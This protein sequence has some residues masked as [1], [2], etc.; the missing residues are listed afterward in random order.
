MGQVSTSTVEFTSDAFTIR[1]FL[2]RPPPAAAAPAVVVIQEWW[3]V[4]D[5]IKDIA[6]RFAREGYVAFAPDLYSRLGYQVTK[7]ATEAANLMA[8]LSSQAALRD[9]NAA[10]QCLTQQPGVDNRRVGVVGFCMGGTFALTM[11]T[12]NS[13]I[14]A[15]VSFYGKVPPVETFRYQLCPLLYHYAAKDG[16]VTSQEPARVQEGLTKYGKPGVVHTYPQ[17]DH[18]FFNDTRPDVYRADDARLAWERT[19]AFLRQHLR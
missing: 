3:G 19:L 12:H 16:W 4:N 17:A 9:L 18:A 5:H 14:K 2:A 1:G 8:A 15:A 11:A 13:D 6:Q 10:V 7:D